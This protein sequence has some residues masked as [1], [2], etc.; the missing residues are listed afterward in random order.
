MKS[1]QWEQLT[2]ACLRFLIERA[3]LGRPTTYT[4]LNTVLTRR[5]GLRGFDFEH[6][7]ERAAMG[8]LLGLVVERNLPD[9]GLMISALV[10]Y[11]DAN[12]AGSGFYKLAEQIGLL[13]R[14]ASPQ[15]RM[16]F[17]IKQIV[18]LQKRYSPAQS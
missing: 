15:A 8:R 1:V 3:R 14:G 6:A 13:E 4:E 17:W 5:T 2:E 18:G 16:D 12:D 11:I 7:D 10:Q 9:T